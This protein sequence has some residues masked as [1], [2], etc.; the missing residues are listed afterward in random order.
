MFSSLVPWRYS[1]SGKASMAGFGLALHPGMQRTKAS[2]RS[3]GSDLLPRLDQKVV[4]EEGISTRGGEWV[5][6]SFWICVIGLRYKMC[7]VWVRVCLHAHAFLLACVCM[8]A[9]AFF[10]ACVC[11]HKRVCVFLARTSPYVFP[12]RHQSS[13]RLAKVN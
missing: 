9:C 3:V 11:V 4:F 8:Y 1:F 7:C 12:V 10:I 13:K 6:L 5:P 2:R